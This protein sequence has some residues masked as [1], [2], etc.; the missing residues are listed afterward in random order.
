MGEFNI[1]TEKESSGE[2]TYKFD[3][4]E[5]S[6]LDEAKEHKRKKKEEEVVE[7]VRS[8]LIQMFGEQ[9]PQ[10]VSEAFGGAEMYDIVHEVVDDNGLSILDSSPEMV[11][12]AFL[13]SLGKRVTNKTPLT[14]QNNGNEDKEDEDEWA[15]EEIDGV[16]TTPTGD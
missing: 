9:A 2:I 15:T 16:A 11:F 1:S 3:G 8:G 12:G 4:V 14:V 7:Y 10:K 13:T 5:Y 6:D